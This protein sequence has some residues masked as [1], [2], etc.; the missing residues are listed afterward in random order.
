MIDTVLQQL[1]QARQNAVEMQI[2]HRKTGENEDAEY[3]LGVAM[4][5]NCAKQIVADVFCAKEHK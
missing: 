5:F 4:G 1:E 2:K 3:W